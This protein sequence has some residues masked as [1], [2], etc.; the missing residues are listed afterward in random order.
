MR[1]YP[2]VA[3]SAVKAGVLGLARSLASELVPDRIRVVAICPG[4]TDTPM[5]WASTPGMDRDLVIDAE[6]VAAA[7]RFV[8]ELPRGTTVEPL[9]IQAVGYE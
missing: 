7:V 8:T 6:S 1:G 3:Y 5:R 4:P 2:V 9:V